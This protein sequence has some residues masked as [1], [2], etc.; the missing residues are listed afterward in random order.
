MA[1]VPRSEKEPAAAA[2]GLNV[3][4]VSVIILTFRR[5]E[6]LRAAIESVLSQEGLRITVEVVVVD[7]DP[8]RSAE[9]SYLD[10]VHKAALLTRYVSEP[11]AGI[12]HARN[13]GVAAS[14]GR[15][16]AF[17][18]DDEVAGPNWLS[19]L[20]STVH[21]YEADI[22]LGPVK[23]HYPDG[24]L[25]PSCA[26]QLYNRDALVP[27]GQVVRRFN[28]GNSILSR[29]RCLASTTP[30]DP[31]FGLTGG[32]DS[33]LLA[34]LIDEGRRCVWCSEAVVTETI[35]PERL[36]PLY[37]LGRALRQG[38]TTAYLPSAL[39]HP[40]WR[41]VLRWMAIG[42]AQFCIFAPWGV[43]LRLC[44]RD[45]WLSAM[46]KAASGLGKV[47]WHLKLHFR[48]YQLRRL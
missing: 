41:V 22:V 30:F 18:D 33:L 36:T 10:V 26:N 12:S 43:A 9:Q 48:I 39:A 44:G 31:R 37:M 8:E 1:Y 16:I 35:T 20:L 40:Q 45:E 6:L 47:F 29:E 42:A 23:P 34:R 17:L 46:V 11:R 5:P 15:Y 27:T 24:F 4:E 19:S 14:S 7:N 28:I 25:I 32:E 21:D 3:T 2:E 13:A 38:Q